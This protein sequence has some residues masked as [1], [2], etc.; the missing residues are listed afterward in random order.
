MI[1]NES[2]WA[3]N[4]SKSDIGH[5][6]TLLGELSKN[7][8]VLETSAGQ[9]KT[10]IQT[11]INYVTAGSYIY[12]DSEISRLSNIFAKDLSAPQLTQILEALFVK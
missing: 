11:Y 9:W 1:N 4:P 3:K 10:L 5:H 2:F 7:R 8:E 6:L 12:R